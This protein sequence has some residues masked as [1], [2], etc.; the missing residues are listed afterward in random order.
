MATNRHN[1][2]VWSLRKWSEE[3]PTAELVD[4]RIVDGVVYG[5]IENTNLPDRLPNG[6]TVTL[7]S[8]KIHEYS[9]HYF[10]VTGRMIAKA[11][12]IKAYKLKEKKL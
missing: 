1:M 9:D 4:F 2:K 11:L 3:N 7:S 5:K 12:Y 8:F 10:F 6:Q